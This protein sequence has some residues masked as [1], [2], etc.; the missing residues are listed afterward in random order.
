MA[1]GLGGMMK[2]IQQM[3]EKMVQA[4]AEL[5]TVKVEGTAGGGMV[6]AVMNGKQELLEIKIEPDV[7]DPAEKEM[8]EEL[9][10]AAISHL[11]HGRCIGPRL[12]LEPGSLTN[13]LWNQE[14]ITD[15]R[16]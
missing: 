2:Q 5:E 9:V 7:I 15:F 4:Q 1:K 14:Y 10:V 13:I 3:Q 16:G 6:K 8:L 11:I 12:I